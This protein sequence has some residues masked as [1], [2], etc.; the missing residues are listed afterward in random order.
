VNRIRPA[1]VIF[2]YGNVLSAP[3]GS[4]EVEAM[5]SILNAEIDRFLKAYWQFRLAY[6][7]AA[8][9]PDAYWRKTANTLSSDLTESQIAALIEIDSRSW[10][11]PAPYI[12]EWARHLH[13]AGVMTALLSNMPTPV[14]DFITHCDWLPPFHHR[15]FSC[16]LRAAKPAPEVYWDCIDALA[17]DPPEILFLDDRPENTRA[18]EALGLRAITYTTA[19]Q[20]ALE[21]R[22][23]FDMLVPLVGTV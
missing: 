7:A 12:P 20:A 1:A 15:T 8:L 19:E 2:D 9:D 5:A 13:Q 17:V 14:R 23:R 3:Q 4:G 22:E 6:D 21:L 18:A 10:A 16:D 11:Y